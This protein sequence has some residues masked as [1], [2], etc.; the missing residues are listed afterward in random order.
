MRREGEGWRGVRGGE[1]GGLLAS[2]RLNKRRVKEMEREAIFRDNLLFFMDCN[3]KGLNKGSKGQTRGRNIWRKSRFKVTAS[4]TFTMVGLTILDI[5]SW[6][7]IKVYGQL[8]LRK[9]LVPGAI[10]GFGLKVTLHKGGEEQE[11]KEAW[12]DEGREVKEWLG[13]QRKTAYGKWKASHSPPSNAQK[14][15]D[16]E[17][18]SCVHNGCR[19]PA[20]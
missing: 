16:T 19:M 5:Q 10:G 20:F 8:T 17:P 7:V 2:C 11:R 18:Q 1:G 13:K 14:R 15:I 4:I 6:V 12:M 3:R 9:V